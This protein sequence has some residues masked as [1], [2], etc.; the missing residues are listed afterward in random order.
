MNNLTSLCD[1]LF[2]GS[3]DKGFLNTLKETPGTY[4]F[5]LGHSLYTTE[6]GIQ[7]EKHH[8]FSNA[9]SS[10]LSLAFCKVKG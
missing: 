6:T 5:K 3:V 4:P 8:C 2:T 9:K 7:S 1:V 10:C